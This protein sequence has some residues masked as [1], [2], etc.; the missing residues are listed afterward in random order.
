MKRQARTRPL[1]APQYPSIPDAQLTCNPVDL[2]RTVDRRGNRGG[3]RRGCLNRRC[4]NSRMRTRK[5]HNK[6]REVR[7][8]G[9][10]VFITRYYMPHGSGNF[11]ASCRLLAG[12]V[13]GRTGREAANNKPGPPAAGP[14]LRIAGWQSRRKPSRSS[15]S[16]PA[17]GQAAALPVWCRAGSG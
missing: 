6:S 14:G 2:I 17:G 7:V 13:T 16:R 3:R 15:C 10:L 8:A 12:G 11:P 1:P 5:K 9:P 4:V